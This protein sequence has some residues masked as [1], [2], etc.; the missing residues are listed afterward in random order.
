MSARLQAFA[1]RFLPKG[2]TDLLR[3]IVLFCG[4]YY[5]YRIVRG[6]VDG[7]AASAFDN[8]NE[9]IS[10]ERA[11]GLFIEPTVHAWAEGKAWIIDFASWM[12]VNS[13]FSITV[14]TLAFIY[15]YRN[16]QFY[17]VRNMF[18]LAMG[19]ALLAYVAYPTAPPRFMPEFGFS[20]SVA[21]FTGVTADSG[22]ANALF[23]PF[24]A[25]PSMHVAF[26]LMLGLPMAKMSRR[27]WVRA[28]WLVYPL[29]V[30]FVVV[31]TANHW[32]L[33]AFLGALTAG[34]S[35]YGALWFGRARPQAWAF[36]PHAGA[37]A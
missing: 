29:I 6:L 20:D 17:F 14:V 37:A 26:A 18:M 4:A 23:N 32:W 11:M 7:R 12:Y 21:E 13:H 9:L 24:A 31:A 22:S 2:W 28:L 15:L 33:D 25:V 16:D 5:L 36:R 1:G 8:A 19:I 10:I 30:S 3:Q 34:V 27:K 35:A